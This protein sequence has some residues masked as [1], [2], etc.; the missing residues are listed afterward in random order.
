MHDPR[1]KTHRES[2]M[3]K[4]EGKQQM[5]YLKTLRMALQ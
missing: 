5:L 3:E 4:K 2:I 1:R